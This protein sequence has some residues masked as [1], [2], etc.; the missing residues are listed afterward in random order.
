MFSLETVGQ[1][2]V[3]C[4]LWASLAHSLFLPIKFYWST[5]TS[6]HLQTIYGCFCTTTAERSS[7][8]RHHTM[9]PAKPK[10]FTLW[11]LT[12]KVCQ[13]LPCVKESVAQFCPTLCN[14]RDSSLQVSSICR[15]LQARI[16]EW[17]AIPFS[18]ESS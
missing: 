9:W 6:V 8:H 15:R 2:L 10:I 17:I 12:E 13:S 16:L 3:S 14:P 7:C 11:P 1:G 18:R 5:G 4:S